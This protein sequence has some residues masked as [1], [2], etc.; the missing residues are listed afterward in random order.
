VIRHRLWCALAVT[1]W[2]LSGVET[3]WAHPES[4]S[5]AARAVAPD[6]LGTLAR[7]GA[8]M[9]PTGAPPAGAA[10][11]AAPTSS[12][13]FTMP[14]HA[15]PAVALLAGGVALLAMIPRGRRALALVVAG[16]LIAVSLEGASHA[17]LH[18]GH[19]PHKHALVVG[20][21]PMPP[22]G[23]GRDSGPRGDV[24]LA[25]LGAAPESSPPP[26]LGC[27]VPALQGRSPPLLVA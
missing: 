4:M 3:G 24:I 7:N 13:P 2:A 27:A 5:V 12:L 21:P 1:V 8:I 16:L 14:H 9:G 18:L 10:E 25:A 15:P 20:V 26:A 17:L 23:D 6:A 19:V 11:P 22:A